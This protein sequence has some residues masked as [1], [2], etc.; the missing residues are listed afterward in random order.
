MEMYKL[1]P[2]MFLH[3]LNFYFQNRVK[4]NGVIESNVNF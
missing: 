4:N 3:T 2:I 1:Q